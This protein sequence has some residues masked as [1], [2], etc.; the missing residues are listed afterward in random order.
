MPDKPFKSLDQLCSILV[1]ER[2]L[3]CGDLESLRS[4]LART[5]YYRFSGYAREFQVNPRYGDNRFA[6]G[7]SFEGIREIIAVDSAMRSL[8]MQ[9]LAV[10]E[11]AVRSMVAHEYGRAYGAGAFYLDPGFY[12]QGPNP[13]EDRPLAIVCGI[14]GDLERDKSR[15]VLRYA[16]G[17]VRGSSF[18][19]RVERY[20]NVPIWV[21]VE[22]MSFGRVSNLISYAGDAGPAKA[23]AAS[24]SLQWAPFAEVVHSL[25]VLRNMCA[26]HRQLWNRRMGILC[27]VQK[28]LRRGKG[29]FDPTSPY[30]HLVMLNHYRLKIDGDSSVAE[31]IDSLLEGC[32][33]YSEGFRNPNPK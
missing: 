33:A 15:M 7:A 24:F 10:V 13:E 30:C 5:N 16:D 11:V 19:S 14:L 32:P 18:E 3:V 20:A 2:K 22:A 12:S 9:Q 4:Y 17:G 1:D 28:K 25:S 26:H 27:P 6:E 8:L 29:R 21:A 31:R 23:A